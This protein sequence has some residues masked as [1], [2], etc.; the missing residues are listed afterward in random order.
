VD[1]SAYVYDG[2]GHVRGDLLATGR[3]PA[4]VSGL[5]MHRIPIL[6]L[7]EEGHEYDL[8]VTYTASDWSCKSEGLITI[9]FTVGGVLS[10]NDGEMGGDAANAMLSHFAIEWV[11]GAGGSPFD[12]GK[13]SDGYPPPLISTDSNTNYGLF[14]TSTIGQEIYSLGWQADVHVG[15]TLYAWVFEA[16]GTS[17]GALI[18][19]GTTVA[20]EGESRW[21]DIPVA[22]TLEA[23]ADYNIEIGFGQMNQWRYWEDYSGMPYTPYGLFEVYATSQGGSTSSHRLIHMRVHSCNASATG[24]AERTKPLP[25]FTLYAP[26]PNPA[27][28]SMS[29]DYSI[30]EEG[31]VTVALYDVTGRRVAIFLDNEFRPVGPGRINLD[32]RGIASGVYFVRME[33][34]GKSVSQRITVVR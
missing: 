28:G 11:P 4:E 14:I 33:V 32:T 15:S 1:I 13:M 18:S 6:A 26:Y 16:S 24:V 17:R 8:A 23:G 21:H 27:I 34:A 7:L 29:L 30:D 12:L 20:V 3:A 19:E 25:T 9:P 10:V 31:P 22:A 2:T 5:T